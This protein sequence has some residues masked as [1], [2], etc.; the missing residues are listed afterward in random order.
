MT[1]KIYMEKLTMV[2]KTEDKKTELVGVQSNLRNSEMELKMMTQA[3]EKQNELLEFAYAQRD[4]KERMH[5]IA[6][7]N[8]KPVTPAW[9]FM[10]DEEYNELRRQLSDTEFKMEMANLKSTTENAER[11]KEAYDEQVASLTET[12]ARLKEQVAELETDDE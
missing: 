11:Q 1:D 5:A 3:S 10:K 8:F 7:A 9:E 6:M 2:D 4:L 12:I